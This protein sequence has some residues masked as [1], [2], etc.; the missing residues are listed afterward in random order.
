[1]RDGA[2]ILLV[3]DDPRDAELTLRALRKNH[4]VNEVRVLSD[5]AQALEH[6]MGLD[7]E[8][9][10]RPRPRLILLDLK[11]PKVDG[12]GVLRAVREDP[13]LSLVPVV[14]L[15]S[16]R[17]ERDLLESYRLG[18]NSYIV[19]PVEFEAFIEAVSQVGLYWLLLNQ[20]PAG[21]PEV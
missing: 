13:E 11:L 12:L 17:E 15:T 6:L 18:V 10:R 3:E 21:A 16:S 9:R 14:M 2:E 20:A 19:K 7:G 8:G 5:G 4:V 1:M